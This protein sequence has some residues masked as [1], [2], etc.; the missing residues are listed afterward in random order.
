M[1]SPLSKSGSAKPGSAKSLSVD[2]N[3]PPRHVIDAAVTRALAEDLGE[4]GDVT[5]MACV[6]ADARLQ[7][8]MRARTPGRAAGVAVAAAVFSA[9]SDALEIKIQAP[10]GARFAQLDPILTVTG[11]A[12]AILAGERVALNFAQR[13]SGIATLTAQYVAAVDGGLARITGTRKTTPGLRALE[14]F[15]IRAG[16][17]A[18][19]RFALDDAIMIKD[20]HIAAAGG[21]GAALM[22]ARARGGHML[23]VS[24]EVDT[25]EQ[26][27]EAMRYSPD[28]VL[29]DNF[30]VAD[31]SRAVRLIGGRCTV[32]ASGGVTLETV[33]EIADTGVDIISVGALTHSA[34]A[35]DLG[36]DVV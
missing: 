25:L 19:H 2:L 8:V 36:L 30:A 16:G 12:R 27:E 33:K 11:P 28:V 29:C 13:L 17:G 26:L 22:A 15:A 23:H 3:P 9:V 1:R 24:V 31:L 6:P 20:N 14:K 10:D 18:S 34:P 5:G 7:A 35:L 4:M 21:V 32:E